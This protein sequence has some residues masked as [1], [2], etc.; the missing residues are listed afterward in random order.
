MTRI[1]AGHFR[2]RQ[3][4]TPR[5]NATRPTAD[6]V[7]EALFTTID[8]MIGQWD[9]TRVLDLFAGSGA[10]GLEAIS[11]GA[12]SADLVDNSP[13]AAQAVTANI[14]TLAADSAQFR[15]MAASRF[16]GGRDARRDARWD[17]VFIDPPYD[18]PPGI[19][20]QLLVALRPQLATEPVIVVERARGTEFNW[21]EPYRPRRDK[22]YGTTRLWYGQ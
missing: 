19:L 12:A 13:R 4:Q 6:R 16:I 21:P 5:G 18:L 9:G 2:G 22:T 10:L 1:I 15:R 17:V 8:S 11:R 3:L 20:D 14:R 7:R